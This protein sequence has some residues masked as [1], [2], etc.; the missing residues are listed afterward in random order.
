M[1][2]E[3]SVIGSPVFTQDGSEIGKVKEIHGQFF[4]VDAPFQP[5]YWLSEDHLASD[6]GSHV[7]LSFTE[8]RLSDYKLG[9]PEDYTPD[10]DG[11]MVD[12]TGSGGGYRGG[13][14]GDFGRGSNDGS[15]LGAGI[16]FDAD[17]PGAGSIRARPTETYGQESDISRP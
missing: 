16:E 9:D 11:T 13:G 6:S 2:L 4:K 17:K 14:T 10:G 8:D 7:R 3:Q 12:V 1:R 5:D 15:G